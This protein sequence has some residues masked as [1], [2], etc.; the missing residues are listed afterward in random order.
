MAQRR[1]P[2]GRRIA[3]YALLH[4]APSGAN[5]GCRLSVLSHH[6]LPAFAHAPRRAKGGVQRAGAR[7]A[8]AGSRP[9]SVRCARVSSRSRAVP[10][11][12]PGRGRS[13][14]ASSNRPATWPCLSWNTRL[15]FGCWIGLRFPGAG[16]PSRGCV[17]LVAVVPLPADRS[18]R[19][20]Y[21]GGL[22]RT[23]VVWQPDRNQGG[24]CSFCAADRRPPEPKDHSHEDAGK[25][26]DRSRHSGLALTAC[27]TVGGPASGTHET[28][29]ERLHRSTFSR[30][31]CRCLMSKTSPG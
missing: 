7:S 17:R 1:L 3:E 24:L 20:R 27:G 30:R 4:R 11:R 10:D 19:S 6:G 21:D 9:G 28:M 15:C 25:A 22:R 16:G 13:L 26:D 18:R 23:A 5:A 14:S 8:F 2:E 31:G 12:G 29:R